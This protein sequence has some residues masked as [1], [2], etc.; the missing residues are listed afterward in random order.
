MRTRSWQMD[1]F[2]ERKWTSV[3]DEIAEEYP[4]TVIVNEKEFATMVCTPLDMEVLVT[5]FL[6]SEGIIRRVNEIKQLEVDENRGF[7]YV[8]TTT[9]LPPAHSG[10]KRW[11][12]SCCG[13]SRAFYFQSD[14]MTAR[15][16]MDET[17]FSPDLCYRRME[18]FQTDADMFQ[19][20]GGVHQAAIA[21]KKGILKAYTDIGRHNALDKLYGYLLKENIS[22][23]GK[24]ILFTGRISSE[25]LLKISKMG[26]GILLSKSA[27]TDLALELADD[28]NMTAVGFL[29]GKRMNVYTHSRRIAVTKEE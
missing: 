9:K 1:R 3:E 24:M 12:G 17:I 18:E 27:P 19:R 10:Q 11:L 26:V 25:V 2:Q 23:K 21:C 8:E 22:R 6:A 16:V 14:A 4:L 15:T 28:L 13:T 29:R 5:G 7:A 20:T